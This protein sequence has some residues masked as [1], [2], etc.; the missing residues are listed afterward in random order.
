MAPA[1]TSEAEV[2]DLERAR[3]TASRSR[4][5]SC[6][7]CTCRSRRRRASALL[8]E[9]YF[10]Y[11]VVVEAGRRAWRSFAPDH[12]RRAALP[13]ALQIPLVLLAR[14]PAARTPASNERPA[15]AGDRGVRRRAAPHRQ[16]PPRR[17]GAGSRRCCVRARRPRAT[18]R[19]RVRG[20]ARRR[21]GDRCA[22]RCGAAL[23]ARRDLPARTSTQRGSKRRSADLMAKLEPGASRARC[24]STSPTTSGSM[25][26]S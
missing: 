17:R 18:R 8:F 20:A 12:D 3:R 25:R 2:S 15:A 11:D 23:A 14:P 4:S 5:A 22:T 16:R 10:R 26:P 24:R 6:S 21:R 9:A 19:R 7:R 13:R 1:A